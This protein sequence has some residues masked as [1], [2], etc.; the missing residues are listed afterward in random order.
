MHISHFDLSAFLAER[1]ALNFAA[2]ARELRTDEANLRKIRE[3]TRRIP[4]HKRG[5]Y[6]EVLK[7]YGATFTQG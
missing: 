3:G 6:I 4:A 1:P 5:Q 2:L 7:K